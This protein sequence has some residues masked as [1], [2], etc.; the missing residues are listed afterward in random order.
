MVVA[1]PVIV[2]VRLVGRADDHDA[3]A[4]ADHVDRRCVQLAQ[5]L[6]AQHLARRADAEPPAGEVEHPVDVLEDR[7]HVVGDEQHAE[8][9]LAA[10]PVDQV[11]DDPLRAQV[12]RDQR[13]VAQQQAGVARERLADAQ[14]L[15]LAAGEPGYRHARVV[16][17]ADG[18]EQGVDALRAGRRSG[19]GTPQR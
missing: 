10:V 6:G 7:V 17:G 3:P 13:L 4:R 2:R 11:A 12:E 16:R 14:P 5:H 15:L 18:V 1:V 19:S 9:A 8:P